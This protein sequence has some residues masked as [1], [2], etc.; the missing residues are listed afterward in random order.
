M[1]PR[2]WPFDCAREQENDAQEQDRN[3]H[4][5]RLESQT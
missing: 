2:R 4:F 5:T 1:I 3:D